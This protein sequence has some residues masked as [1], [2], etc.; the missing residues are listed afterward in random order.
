MILSWIGSVAISLTL[1]YVIAANIIRLIMWI[2]CFRVKECN[3]RHCLC[4]MICNKYHKVLTE[5]EYNQLLNPSIIFAVCPAHQIIQRTSVVV[6]KLYKDINRKVTDSF[7][8]PR[9]YIPV[10]P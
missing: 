8:V 6:C 3:R 7:F 9:I 1:I 10:Q 2:K 5:K 4:N